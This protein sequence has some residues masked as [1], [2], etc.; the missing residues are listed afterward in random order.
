MNS[1]SSSPAPRRHVWR[2]VFLGL[3]ICLAPFVILAAVAAS[4]LGLESNAA[5]LRKQVMAATDTHWETK[6]QMSIGR[7]TLGAIRT[8][9]VF[10][11]KKEIAEARQALKAVQHAS[12]GV[13]ERG[14]M[15]GNWSRKELFSQTDASMQKRGWT[16]L[17]GV[18]DKDDTV[19]VY[20]PKDA[21]DDEMMEVC[22]AVISGK[23]LVVVSTRMDMDAINEIVQK[24]AFDDMKGHLRLANLK[25]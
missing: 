7:V 9:L 18:V 11:H 25:F 12:V 14:S 20:V 3:G 15:G 24:H 13:Y 22:L 6:V 10:V 8:G 17:V 21:A 4:Y 23:E 2:W 16:R 19:L 5:L 1:T